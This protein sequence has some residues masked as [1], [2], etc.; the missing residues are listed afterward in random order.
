MRNLCTGLSCVLACSLTST[1]HA[2]E[3]LLLASSLPCA[4]ILPLLFVGSCSGL[5]FYLQAFASHWVR[6]H[7]HKNELHTSWFAFLALSMSSSVA[8]SSVLSS[9]TCVFTCL[10]TNCFSSTAQREDAETFQC[11]SGIPLLGVLCHI[12]VLWSPS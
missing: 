10:T 8:K 9:V 5:V 3:L 1:F 6:L 7:L 2:H 11:F 12:S 4:P